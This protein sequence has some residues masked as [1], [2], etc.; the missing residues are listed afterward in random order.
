MGRE[1]EGMNHGTLVLIM[2]AFSGATVLICVSSR[3]EGK[4]SVYP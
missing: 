3:E 4:T 2:E 1:T